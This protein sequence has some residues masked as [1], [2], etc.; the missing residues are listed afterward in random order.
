MSI[1]V[2]ASVL[3][4]LGLAAS[5]VAVTSG[6]LGDKTTVSWGVGG[7]PSSEGRWDDRD[8]SSQWYWDRVLFLPSSERLISDGGF[9]I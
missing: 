4:G 8:C 9:T 3:L 2:S 5:I 1:A 7:A 6:L